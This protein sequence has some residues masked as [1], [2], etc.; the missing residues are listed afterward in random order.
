[1]YKV[2]LLKYLWNG[3]SAE[4]SSEWVLFSRSLELPFAP[5]PGLGIQ[6][7]M[8]RSWRLR[9][10]DW[11]VDAQAFCCHAEDQYMDGLDDYFDDWIESLTEVGW[12]LEQG[13]YPKN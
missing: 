1:M 12:K 11:V 7:P 13:P 4:D 5:V 9:S 2:T 8:Q 6:L 3:E 10:A